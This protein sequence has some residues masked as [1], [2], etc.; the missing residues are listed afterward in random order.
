MSQGDINNA[1]QLIQVVL[2]I[3]PNKT[4][5]SKVGAITKAQKSAKLFFE[6][7]LKFLNFLSENVA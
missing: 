2:T 7:N 3:N 5:T 4:G 1:V 6:K